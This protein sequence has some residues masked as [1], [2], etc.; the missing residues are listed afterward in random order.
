MVWFALGG[1]V[2]A[3][4]II[5]ALLR[6]VEFEDLEGESDEDYEMETAGDAFLD[7]IGVK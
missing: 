6:V 7:K 5:L 4:V 2:L 1:N 3:W